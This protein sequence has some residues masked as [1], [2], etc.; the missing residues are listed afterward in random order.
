MMK[1][2]ILKTL[3]SNFVSCAR[4]SCGLSTLPTLRMSECFKFHSG[5]HIGKQ[6]SLSFVDL[7]SKLQSLNQTNVMSSRFI[8]EDIV[9]SAFRIGRRPFCTVKHRYFPRTLSSTLLY[10]SRPCGILS[11]KWTKQAL[12]SFSPLFPRVI[13]CR[14]Y[15][16]DRYNESVS[17]T[18]VWTKRLWAVVR[19]VVRIIFLTTGA[20]V[21]IATVVGYLSLERISVNVHEE[22]AGVGLNALEKK[23]MS[24]FY[25]EKDDIAI[26]RK[27][28]ALDGIWKKLKEEE[29]IVEVFGDPVYVCGYSYIGKE[30][31]KHVDESKEEPSLST[32]VEFKEEEN[33]KKGN[34]SEQNE[35]EEEDR[36]EGVKLWDAGCFIEG[37]KKVGLMNVKFEEHQNEWVPVALRLETLEKSGQV[38]SDISGSL[39]NGIKNFTRLSN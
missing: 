16:R 23:L 36:T 2:K 19:R 11:T 20:L 22:Q 32:G 12:V 37:T 24:N 27:E 1:I 3:I 15:Q 14:S 31:V 30:F 28:D 39:P 5:R 21:W 10:Q 9:A 26:M 33:A 25:N 4:E 8:F 29:R 6:V 17:R 34:E 18:K 13:A 7:L 35:S 38:V